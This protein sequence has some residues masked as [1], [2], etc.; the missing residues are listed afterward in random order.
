M[1][2]IH[3]V[4]QVNSLI[5]ITIFHLNFEAQFNDKFM[6]ARI[7][8]EAHI[9]KNLKINL[10]LEIDNLISQEIIIDFIKQ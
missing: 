7:K 2:S 8:I 10:F 5:E 4:R 1:I 6:I 3:D 9:V